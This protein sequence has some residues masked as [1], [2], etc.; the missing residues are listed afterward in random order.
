[1]EELL[2]CWREAQRADKVSEGLLRIRANLDQEF[3]D[4][5]TAVL[6]EVESVSRLLRDVYDLFP[7][8]RSRIPIVVYYLNVLLPPIQRTIKEMSLYLEHENLPARAQWTLMS[9]RL[10]HQGG[11]SLG[12]RFVMFVGFLVQ[13]VRLL[14]RHP[15]ANVFRSVLYDA[16]ALELLRLR[17]LRLRTLQNIPE[18]LSPM[19]PHAAP[20]HPTAADLEKR[21]WAEKI[22]DNAPGSTTRLKHLRESQCF[23]PLMVETRLGISLGSC[24]LFKLPFEKN[25]ISVIFFLVP[26]SPDTIRVLCRWIDKYNNPM[27]SCFGVHELE[28]RRKGSSLQLRR[29]SPTRG[30]PTLWLALFFKTWESM[31]SVSYIK[32]KSLTMGSNTPCPSSKTKVVE[33]YVYSLLASP[34]WIKRR[35]RHR[36][37]LKDFSPYVFCDAYKKRHQLRKNGAF[38][39]YFLNEKGSYLLFDAAH[40]AV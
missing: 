14:S 29:W 40:Q 30:H 34:D 23:G 4:E 5:I 25:R 33:Q 3:H 18:P 37:W 9:D 32:G 13:T 38:E 20:P 26:E 12:A 11:M 24:A 36:I 8:Y 6:R 1:M 28:I 17:T 35:S 39:V 21:H 19:R 15:S 10:S 7:I 16:T 27:Y 2:G 22:F 31:F